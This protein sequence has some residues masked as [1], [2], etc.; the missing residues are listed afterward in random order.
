MSF[1]TTEAFSFRKGNSIRAVY[2]TMAAGLVF[3]AGCSSTSEDDDVLGYEPKARATQEVKDEVGGLSSRVLEMLRVKGK[4][5]E[6]G[7][8]VSPCDSSSGAAKNTYR[9]RHPWS[10]YGVG[11]EVMAKGMENLR[12]E[13]PRQGWKIE[14]SGP[15]GSENKNPEILAVHLK[16]RTQ[17]EAT[18]LKGQDG[19]EPLIEVSLYSRC[20]RATDGSDAGT[21]GSADV[22]GADTGSVG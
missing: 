17:L 10:V 16:T 5:T 22:G 15:D 4:A 8:A 20:F 7:P 3:I 18:W 1:W 11:N 2:L 9:V 19:H 21:T 13:L 6:S 12:E 14:K